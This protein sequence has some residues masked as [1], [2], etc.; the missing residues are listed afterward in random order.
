MSFFLMIFLCFFP[1]KA[2]I[3]LERAPPGGNSKQCSWFEALIVWL[4]RMVTIRLE[5]GDRR[6]KTGIRKCAP[7]RVSHCSA[8]P[9]FVLECWEGGSGQLSNLSLC[10]GPLFIPYPW[11]AGGF[12][13]FAAKGLW[14]CLSALVSLRGLWQGTMQEYGA[15][16]FLEPFRPY[17][18]MLGTAYCQLVLDSRDGLSRCTQDEESHQ[19]WF[20][21]LSLFVD[22]ILWCSS[23]HK[24]DLTGPVMDRGPSE[25]VLWYLALALLQLGAAP[26][27]KS[28]EC[29]IGWGSGEFSRPG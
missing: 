10:C 18:H 1:S 21:E 8:S 29:S 11:F 4:S 13:E 26:P 2:S 16:Q 6:L 9:K 12:M 7:L 22:I 3:S 28:H 5:P 20:S 23:W 19:V 14:P 27:F 24:T 17:V 15:L 25:D